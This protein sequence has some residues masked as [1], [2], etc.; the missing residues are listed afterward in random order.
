VVCDRCNNETLSQLDQVI[1]EFTPISV[2]RTM[3]GIPS[4]AGKVPGLRFSE[5]TID[6]RAGVAGVDP[7][8]IFSSHGSKELLKETGRAPDGR[9]S[10]QLEASGGRRFTPRYGSELS[11]A[12]LKSALECAWLDHGEMTLE[13]RFDHIR[14]AV[15]GTPRDGFFVVANKA[16]PDCREVSLTYDFLRCD[17][18]TWRMLVWCNYYGIGIATDSRLPKPL[19]ELPP[20]LVTTLTFTESDLRPR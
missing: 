13:T 19:Q 10:L 18:D 1:C 4:K 5:G 16:D 14:D 7:T 11:R 15:L 17:D 9:V 12:L 2:R 6:F 20:G 8:L 3:L